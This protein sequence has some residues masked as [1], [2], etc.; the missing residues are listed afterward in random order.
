M[1]RDQARD[2]ARERHNGR[3]MTMQDRHKIPAIRHVTFTC[4]ADMK[5]CICAV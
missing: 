5:V 4:M 3:G 1:S 2:G